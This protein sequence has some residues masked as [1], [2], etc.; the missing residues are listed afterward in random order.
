[1]KTKPWTDELGNTLDGKE[2]E[3]ASRY[4]TAEDWELFQKEYSEE[5]EPC[6]VLLENGNDIETVFDDG[7]ISLWDFISDD[8]PM[9]ILDKLPKLKATINKLSSVQY[10][11]LRHFYIKKRTDREIAK[12]LSISRYSVKFKRQ[13]VIRKLSNALKRDKSKGLFKGHV[14]I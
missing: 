8:V 3:Q 13:R 11:I 12:L 2:L 5:A 10:R 9:H 7:H 1:M 4:W 14:T 6:E